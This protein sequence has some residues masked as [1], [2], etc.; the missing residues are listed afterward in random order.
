M[1]RL[2]GILSRKIE[3]GRQQT[4]FYFGGGFL[5]YLLKNQSNW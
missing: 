1:M 4:L 2:N 3:N 5:D